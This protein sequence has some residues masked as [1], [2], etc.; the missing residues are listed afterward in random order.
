MPTAEVESAYLEPLMQWRSSINS[1]AGSPFF[2]KFAQG[3]ALAGEWPEP[4]AK[5]LNSNTFDHDE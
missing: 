2:G 1:T 3:L 5:P 4:L